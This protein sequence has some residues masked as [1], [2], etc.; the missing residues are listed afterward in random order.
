[1]QTHSAG[2]QLS[3]LQKKHLIFPDLVL[4]ETIGSLPKITSE[5]FNDT[6]V[7]TDCGR[8]VITTLEFLQHPLS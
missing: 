6:Q 1:M 2:L 8:R 4:G 7:V 3:L 5:V